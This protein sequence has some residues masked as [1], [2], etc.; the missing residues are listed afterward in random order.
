MTAR[1]DTRC[2]PW[3]YSIPLFGWIAR[4][5]VHGTPD[6]L[7]YFLVIVVTLLV[8]AVKAWGLV[9]LTMVALA[10]VP[11]CFALLILISVGK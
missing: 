1:P 8:L 3:Y 10:A 11:V 4:D 6:N 2:L 5:L 7:L 9:A